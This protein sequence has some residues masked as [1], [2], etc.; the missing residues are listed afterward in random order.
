MYNPKKFL[1]AIEKPSIFQHYVLNCLRQT[2][3]KIEISER[4]QQCFSTFLKSRNL[5]NIND[6]S[7]EPKQ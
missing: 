4:V 3:I 2:V 5:L 6:H 1:S 7:M